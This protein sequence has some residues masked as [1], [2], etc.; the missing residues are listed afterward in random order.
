MTATSQ[1]VDT[2]TLPAIPWKNGGGTTRNLAVMPED[3]G[4]DDFLWRISIAEVRESG[5]FSRFRDVD[6]IIVLL[7]GDG[8]TLRGGDGSEISLTTPFV[9][10]AFPGEASID[11][12][13]VNGPTVDFNVMVLRGSVQAS[14]EAWTTSGELAQ[15]RSEAVFYCAKGRYEVTLAEAAVGRV[16]QLE[17]GFMLRIQD[18]T[19]GTRLTPEA[20]GSILLCVTIDPIEP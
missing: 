5:P 4:F 10:H 15:E 17:K 3:A 8:M 18:L 9:P 7:D 16:L 6:R 1:P 13:L 11:A 19:A 2:R 12:R 14:V 20:P